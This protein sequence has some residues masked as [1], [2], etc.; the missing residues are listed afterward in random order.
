MHRHHFYLCHSC[1][2]SFQRSFSAIKPHDLQVPY[3]RWRPKDGDSQFWAKP[4]WN[5]GTTQR[6]EQTKL[7]NSNNNN[8]N[9]NN[10]CE[11][12]LIKFPVKTIQPSSE[13]VQSQKPTGV[14]KSRNTGDKQTI[15]ILSRREINSDFKKQ[16]L[17]VFELQ[18]N[19]QS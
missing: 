3:F 16:I 12:M 15:L 4:K 11:N 5:L 8:N 2:C 14:R 1:H 7:N 6:V 10:N 18:Q 19:I 9:N 17:K 13:V